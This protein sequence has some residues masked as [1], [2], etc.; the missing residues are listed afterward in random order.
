MVTKLEAAGMNLEDIIR[1]TVVKG[2]D[3][4]TI[5]TMNPIGGTKYHR[6]FRRVKMAA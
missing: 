3:K 4:D 2:M 6:A 1:F 5:N